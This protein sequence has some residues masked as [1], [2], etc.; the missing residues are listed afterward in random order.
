MDSLR[1][2]HRASQGISGQTSQEETPGSG[3]GDE[4]PQHGDLPGHRVDHQ[5]LR[6]DQQVPGVPLL[7]GRHTQP[8]H[9]PRSPA[10]PE[11]QP[12]V[13]H[14]PVEPQYRD[15]C[16]Q[17]DNNIF[18]PQLQ[19]RTSIQIYPSDFLFFIVRAESNDKP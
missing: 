19:P 5:V 7:P 10:G 8:R 18:K 15:H 12:A 14:Q 3:G 6:D 4:A 16:T 17:A 11:H 13:V 2:P 9:L 1:Q